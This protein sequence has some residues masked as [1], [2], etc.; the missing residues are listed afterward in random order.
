[1][2]PGA[3]QL[4][5]E[6]GLSAVLI[7]H[8]GKSQERA[9]RQGRPGPFAAALILLTQTGMMGFFRPLL[10]LFRYCGRIDELDIDFLRLRKAQRELIAMKPHFHRVAHGG[11]LD[12]R[13]FHAR[14]YAHIKEML[15]ERAFAADFFYHGTLAGFQIIDCHHCR[16]PDVK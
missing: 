15:T 8:Q 13:D 6:R 1:M 4:V 11:Q 12:Q 16:S 14:D 7:A 2:L 5:E 10:P 3:G 9:V